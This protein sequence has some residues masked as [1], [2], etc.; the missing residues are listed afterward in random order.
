MTEN[1]SHKVANLAFF[2]PFHK[3]RFWRFTNAL[4]DGFGHI[5]RSAE[6]LSI[7]DDLV[8]TMPESIDGCSPEEFVGEGLSPLA[9]VQIAGDDRG[10]PFIAF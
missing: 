8:G 9:Q 5:S 7:K 6:T 10:S 3:S 1:G 2:T 4:F